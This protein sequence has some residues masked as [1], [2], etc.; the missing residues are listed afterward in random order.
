MDQ[1]LVT[2]VIPCFRQSTFFSKSIDS[3]LAVSY[4]AVE[5]IVINDGSDDN[6]DEVARAYGDRIRYLYQT[7]QGQAAARNAGISIA[8]GK[9]L[10]FLDADDLLHPEAIGWLVEATQGSDNVLCVMGV[11]YFVNEGTRVPRTNSTEW[12][13]S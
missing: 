8:N 2:I 1:P 6:T 9:Y 4:P 13:W 11:Q 7:N 10:L 5:I 12:S 3:A